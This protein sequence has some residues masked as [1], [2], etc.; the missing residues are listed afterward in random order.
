MILLFER[1]AEAMRDGRSEDAWLIADRVLAGRDT[2][3]CDDP[4]VDYHRRWVWDGTRIDGRDVL[5][6][7]YHGLGDT[8]QFARLLPMARTRAAKLTVE[9]QPSLCRLLGQIDD[10]RVVPFDRAHPLPKSECDVEI[11]ELP[12]ALR[13]DLAEAPAQYLAVRPQ[14]LARGTIGI[15]YGA[16]DWDDSRSIPHDL[17]APLCTLRPTITLVAEPTGLPVRNPEGCPRDMERTAALVAGCDLVITVD[18]MIAHLAGALGRPTWLLLKAEPDWRWPVDGRCTRIY[19]RTRLYHQPV[20]GEW[21]SAIAA[22]RH[23]LATTLEGS[24]P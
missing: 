19:P 21:G 11:G 7:C 12:H 16:G 22:V 13:H 3:L 18:T 15:C 17:F 10:I 20:A 14:S 9:A 24:L 1:W 4:A 23:D 2:A 5:V 6:R 8:L